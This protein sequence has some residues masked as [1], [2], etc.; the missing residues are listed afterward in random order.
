MYQALTQREGFVDVKVNR[1]A[2]LANLFLRRRPHETLGIRWDNI[3]LESSIVSLQGQQTKTKTA[4]QILMPSII[5]EYLQ[6]I[7]RETTHI[8]FYNNEPVKSIRKSWNSMRLKLTFPGG[9]SLVPYSLRHNYAIFLS[10][11]EVTTKRIRTNMGHSTERI[12]AIYA[13][14]KGGVKMESLEYISEAI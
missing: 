7:P 5:V 8:I 12:T 4:R 14:Y 13:H 3:N 11:H 2:K 6:G 9:K 1:S 10:S